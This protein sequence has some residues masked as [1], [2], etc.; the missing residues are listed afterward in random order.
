MA[1]M[2]G[3]GNRS[4]VQKLLE[5]D[6]LPG[7]VGQDERGHRLADLRRRLAGAILTKPLYEPIHRGGK[8]RPFSSYR[9]SKS[10]KLLLQRYVQIAHAPECIVQGLPSDIRDHGKVPPRAL[11]LCEAGALPEPFSRTDRIQTCCA[12]S[13]QVKSLCRRASKTEPES[14]ALTA[15][16]GA[17]GTAGITSSMREPEMP[18]IK[19][20]PR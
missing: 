5:A 19:R 6:H 20:V 16:A 13:C 12:P 4:P 11:A 9:L 14:P 2:E 10:A 3:H 8:F 17:V 18:V 7:L 15:K 1:A